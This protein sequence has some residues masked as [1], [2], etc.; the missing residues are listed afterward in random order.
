MN[1]TEEQ[2]NNLE[3]G[4][5]P[6]SNRDELEAELSALIADE[7]NGLSD[8]ANFSKNLSHQ[9]GAKSLGEKHLEQIKADLQNGGLIDFE[10]GKRN[11]QIFGFEVIGNDIQP[12]LTPYGDAI[13][14]INFWFNNQ[15]RTKLL[16]LHIKDL[17]GKN[18]YL[19][20]DGENR[21]DIEISNEKFD[22]QLTHD[23]KGFHLELIT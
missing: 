17:E 15:R 10:G 4:Q 18:E 16:V 11:E 20:P 1:M 21:Y 7:S 3:I 6:D 14:P 5:H 8:L 9:E 12:T 19:L 23:N 2:I 13:I 22:Y